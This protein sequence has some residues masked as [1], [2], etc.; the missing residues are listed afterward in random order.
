MPTPIPDKD[1][2]VRYVPWARLRKTEDDVAIGVL[3]SAFRL[4]DNEEYLSATWLEYFKC[5]T[6]EANVESAVKTFRASMDV[7]RKSGFA[8]G[9]VGK[10][11][12]ACF[13]CPKPHK[14][15]IVH[16]PEEDNKAH[17]AL[18][19]WP[20]DNEDLLDLMA[21]EVWS[22]LFLNADLP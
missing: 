11:K 6:R 21:E 19:G 13:S 12:D 8:V 16:E 3:G 2:V 20:R 14:I 18:R 7:K 1:Y 17:A 5:S 9:N 22:E 4:R 10:I 15:R